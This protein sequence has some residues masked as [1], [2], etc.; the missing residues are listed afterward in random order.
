MECFMNL[1]VILVL[2][3]RPSSLIPILASIPLTHLY[4]Y[5]SVSHVKYIYIFA[6]TILIRLQNSFHL[7]KCKPCT[8]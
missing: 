4:V 3:T 7:A 2:G 1:H 5:S 8:C 6:A